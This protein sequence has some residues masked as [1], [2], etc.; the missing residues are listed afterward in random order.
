MKFT[1]YFPGL[2]WR[3]GKMWL[4]WST[5]CYLGHM[6]FLLS[7]DLYTWVVGRCIQSLSRHTI[8]H[9]TDNSMQVI[10][11]WS[12]RT[13]PVE[14][15]SSS[16]TQ[17]RHHLRT[18]Q[19]TA[20]RT[21]FSGSMNTMALCDFDMRRLRRTLTYLPVLTAKHKMSTSSSGQVTW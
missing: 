7:K 20:E 12:R 8:R 19:M 10:N 17:S 14:L 3:T 9:F 16:T 13:P 21:P 11:F 5:V 6:F 2:E 18:V 1:L 4:F 15:S